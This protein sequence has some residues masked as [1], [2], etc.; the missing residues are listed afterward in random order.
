V[1]AAFHMEDDKHAQ[2]LDIATMKEVSILFRWFN[3]FLATDTM[4]IYYLHECGPIHGVI[5]DYSV[6]KI[7]KT[8]KS[9]V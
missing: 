8:L 4:R 9:S 6:L 2:L 7:N 1:Q 5:K 3:T